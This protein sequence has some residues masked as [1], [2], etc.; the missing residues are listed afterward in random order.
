MCFKMSYA[1]IIINVLLFLRHFV[2]PIHGCLFLHNQPQLLSP[3][4][5]NTPLIIALALGTRSGWD[6]GQGTGRTS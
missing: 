2:A 3:Q 1:W 6:E 4:L 5:R